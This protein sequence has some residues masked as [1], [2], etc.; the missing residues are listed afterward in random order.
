MVSDS[1]I[2]RI[3]RTIAVP[4]FKGVRAYVRYA[5][6]RWGKIH[7]WEFAGRWLN[8]YGIRQVVRVKY[9]ARLV[10]S[11][12]DLIQSRLMFFGVWEPGL[13]RLLQLRLQPGDCF[14]DVGANIGY[15]TLLASRLVGERGTVV[16]IE[17][18]PTTSESLKSN[19]RLNLAHNVRV[20]QAAVTNRRGS[21]PLYAGPKD[22]RGAASLRP[23]DGR[24]LE[25]A[26]E[27]I[28]LTEM[29][30]EEEWSRARL[31][32]IDV[33]GTEAEVLKS[34]L[35]N[36]S[37]LRAD[38]E[39]VVEM[40]PAWLSGIGE[41]ADGLIAAFEELGFAAYE[42]SGVPSAT[43]HLTGRRPIIRRLDRGFHKQADIVLSRRKDLYLSVIE[44]R[45]RVIPVETR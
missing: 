7:L 26:V 12:E 40:T 28:P 34:I 15:F 38:A 16:A 10:C 33:E 4:V 13:T 31:I 23:Q 42:L 11:S 6:I 1:N 19:I 5:P 45:D 32:K 29:L 41:S 18:S 44:G 17:A 8:H 35:A 21:I 39:I 27:A 22:N 9:G 3:K 25:A 24:P 20:I 30:S 37:L 43:A 36:P 14:V 2:K